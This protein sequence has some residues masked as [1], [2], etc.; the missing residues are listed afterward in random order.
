[1][2]NVLLMNAYLR[3]DHK[4]KQS[5]RLLLVSYRYD[6]EDASTVKDLFNGK[7]SVPDTYSETVCERDLL[8]QVAGNKG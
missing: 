5:P 1:M 6:T 7:D 3:Q 2:Q 4:L 8:A